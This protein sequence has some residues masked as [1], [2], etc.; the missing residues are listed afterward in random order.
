[1]QT[2]K[3]RLNQSRWPPLWSGAKRKGRFYSGTY[4]HRAV[5]EFSRP[6]VCFRHR[7]LFLESFHKILYSKAS[8]NCLLFNAIN[9]FPS[10]FSFTHLWNQIPFQVLV[11]SNVK[12]ILESHPRL[13]INRADGNGRWWQIVC[14]FFRWGHHHSFVVEPGDRKLIKILNIMLFNHTFE[15]KQCQSIWGRWQ[16]GW[17]EQGIFP[18]VANWRTFFYRRRFTVHY[19]LKCWTLLVD[20]NISD[21]SCLY[22]EIDLYAKQITSGHT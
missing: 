9:Y 16:K 19:Q 12:D 15:V 11:R 18:K 14:Q 10:L 4:S 6:K 20:C 8:I 22:N 1:M 17:F 13:L 2:C 5:R 7:F 3:I 21:V